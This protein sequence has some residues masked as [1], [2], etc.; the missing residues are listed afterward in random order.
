MPGAT[1][2]RRFHGFLRR[3][4]IEKKFFFLARH[5]IL[6]YTPK[7][8]HS[9]IFVTGGSVIADK[10]WP[11]KILFSGRRACSSLQYVHVDVGF[12]TPQARL[13]ENYFFSHR[14]SDAQLFHLLFSLSRKSS[15]TSSGRPLGSISKQKP[16]STAHHRGTL[17]SP[18]DA[19]ATELML[20]RRN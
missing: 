9:R 11:K 13:N 1:V 16:P 5:R 6:I 14:V 18:A 2:R 17:P 3:K 10:C 12:L 4:S 19:A 15:E 7:E 20:L 8:A